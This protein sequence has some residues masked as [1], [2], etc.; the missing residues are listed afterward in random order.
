[1][2]CSVTNRR[3][4]SLI[5]MVIVV[6]ILGILG[7]NCRC[8]K[9]WARRKTATD[10][11]VRQSLCVIRTAI[12]SY[13]AENDGTLPGADGAESTFMNEMAVY[14]RGKEF[15]ACPVGAAKNNQVRMLSG[16]GAV[17]DSISGTEATTV[18]STSSK[19]A[20]F[21]S[22]ASTNPADGTTYDLF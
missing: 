6:M 19:P 16:N 10:N 21:T 5:E 3:G 12:D 7:D 11:G 8:P 17:A 20:I 22:T 14:L 18:G 15:P 4:F 9:F 2:C 1:M 13:S